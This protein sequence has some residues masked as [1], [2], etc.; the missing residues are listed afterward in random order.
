[1]CDHFPAFIINDSYIIIGSIGNIGKAAA[2]GDCIRTGAT[3]HFGIFD[4]LPD[5]VTCFESI[6]NLVAGKVN[7]KH[8]HC[9]RSKRTTHSRN[10]LSINDCSTYRSRRVVR[11][12]MPVDHHIVIIRRIHPFHEGISIHSHIGNK[13]QLFIRTQR[14][15]KW[16]TAHGNTCGNL[17]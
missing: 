9:F 6:N 7:G 14:K 15:A 3:H 12:R 16:L 5:L 10:V 8:T 4:H 1:M 17:F 13:G 11:I 2:N